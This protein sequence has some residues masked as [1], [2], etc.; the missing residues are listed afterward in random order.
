M[1]LGFSS[2]LVG[3]VNRAMNHCLYMS[4]CGVLGSVNRGQL[5]HTEKGWGEGCSGY[6][7]MPKYMEKRV[8]F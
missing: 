5:E 3:N 2:T 8:C 1:H 4:V 7:Y 6:S